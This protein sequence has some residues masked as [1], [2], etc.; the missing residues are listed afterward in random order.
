MHTL[1]LFL[2]KYKMV[3]NYNA[4]ATFNVNSCMHY[5]LMFRTLI[6]QYLYITYLKP[7]FKA[8]NMPTCKL[9]NSCFQMSLAW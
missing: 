9:I 8:R 3:N 6:Q 7:Y 4:Y 2:Q 5:R 1:K